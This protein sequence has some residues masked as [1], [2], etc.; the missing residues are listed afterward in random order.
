MLTGTYEVTETDAF[1]E[2]VE[3]TA[4]ADSDQTGA[5]TDEVTV[6]VVPPGSGELETGGE[7]DGG[8]GQLS[9]TGIDPSGQLRVVLLLLAAGM[10]LV[11][12]ARR[13]RGLRG[14]D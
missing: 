12:T 9:L 11:L 8:G 5:V 7:G 4:S 2:K 13:G 3:N 10:V 1:A 6:P 14:D